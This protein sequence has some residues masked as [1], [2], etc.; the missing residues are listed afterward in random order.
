M[1]PRCRDNGLRL[2]SIT[3]QKA[4][5]EGCGEGRL[6]RVPHMVE[7]DVHVAVDRSSSTTVGSR[8]L[9]FRGV[10]S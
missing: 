2:V 8:L 10:H 5:L 1:V 3:A 7:C 6:E 9:R 4:K